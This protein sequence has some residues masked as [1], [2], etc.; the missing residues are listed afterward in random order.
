MKVFE[1]K[2][3]ENQVSDLKSQFYFRFKQIDI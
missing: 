2:K 1:E 3:I